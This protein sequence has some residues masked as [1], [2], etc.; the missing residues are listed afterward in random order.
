[1]YAAW[2]GCCIARGSAKLAFRKHKRAVLTSHMLEEIGDS[3][4]DFL[5]Q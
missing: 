1:M 3:Y 4:T 5:D 2:S